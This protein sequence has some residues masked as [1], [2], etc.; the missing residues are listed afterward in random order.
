MSFL[1]DEYCN[2]CQD[3][4]QNMKNQEFERVGFYLLNTNVYDSLLTILLEKTP[5]EMPRGNSL[6]QKA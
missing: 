1:A 2:S 6:H 4:L 5:Q 3:I